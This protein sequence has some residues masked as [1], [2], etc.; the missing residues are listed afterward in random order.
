VGVIKKVGGKFTGSHDNHTAKFD[1]PHAA[2][3][4]MAAA[5]KTASKKGSAVPAK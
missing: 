3:R 2:V 4:A 5:K 1:S